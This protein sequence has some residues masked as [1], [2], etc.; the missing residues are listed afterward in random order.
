MGSYESLLA[1]RLIH[2][3]CSYLESNNVGIV[4]GEAGMLRPLARTGSRPRRFVDPMGT[5]PWAAVASSRSTHWFPI[6]PSRYC[7]RATRKRRCGGKL[8]EYFSAGVRLVWYIAP[9]TRTARAY[10]TEDQWQDLGPGNSLS[11]GDVLPGFLLSLDKLF[12]GFP[13]PTGR[14]NSVSG[15]QPYCLQQPAAKARHIQHIVPRNTA[16]LGLPVA[17]MSQPIAE[18]KGALERFTL[19][20]LPHHAVGC[21]ELRQL[22][23]LTKTRSFAIIALLRREGIDAPKDFADWLTSHEHRDPVYGWIYR[24]H[25]RSDAHSIALCK[26]VLRDLIQACQQLKDHALADRIVYGINARHTFPNAKQK[27]LDLA[28]GTPRVVDEGDRFSGAIHRGG[29]ARVLLACE[30]KTCMTEHGKSQPRI[31]DETRVVT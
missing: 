18:L 16:E 23:F 31:F 7:R 4:L 11:G 24:Y 27:T 25:S 26:L 13:G 21:V 19:P 20:D 8:R 22:L 28:V 17:A 9:E 3:L 10:T 12:G 29:I 2:A 14:M 1:V 5:A 15:R 30:A 6:W